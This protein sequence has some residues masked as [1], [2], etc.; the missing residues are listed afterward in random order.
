MWNPLFVNLVSL[1]AC[2]VIFSDLYRELW[3]E[4]NQ[5]K[6]VGSAHLHSFLSSSSKNVPWTYLLETWIIWLSNRLAQSYVILT[7]ILPRVITDHMNLPL[8][9]CMDGELP[10]VP[11]LIPPTDLASYLSC[12]FPCSEVSSEGSLFSPH[13]KKQYPKFKVHGTVGWKTI[14]KRAAKFTSLLFLYS[15]RFSTLQ[16]KR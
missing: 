13:H 2:F 7:G 4:Y 14:S 8:K 3:Q 5:R 6:Q 11:R 16:G 12:C 9:R 15:T 10:F 1:F